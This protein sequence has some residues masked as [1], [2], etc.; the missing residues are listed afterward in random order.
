MRVL[1]DEDLPLA[2]S[3][4]LAP[5]E[6]T[7]VSERGWKGLTNGE[8]LRAAVKAGFDA[9]LTGDTHLPFQQDLRQHDISVVEIR[10]GRL[11]LARLVPLV[12]LIVRALEDAPRRA[13]TIV[14]APQP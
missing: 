6:A 13:L 4:H 9:L 2:L 3:R 10:A 5:H 11:V 7:H 1:L 8:L 14:R 12:P